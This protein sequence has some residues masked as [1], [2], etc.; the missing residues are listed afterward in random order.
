MDQVENYPNVELSKWGLVL[1]QCITVIFFIDAMCRIKRALKS[2]SSVL[3]MKSMCLQM[4]MFSLYIVSFTIYIVY[5]LL[6]NAYDSNTLTVDGPYLTNLDSESI[7]NFSF[8]VKQKTIASIVELVL[9]YSCQIIMAA[10]LL[11]LLTP[12]H[13]VKGE[14]TE[15][16]EGTEEEESELPPEMDLKNTF[17]TEISM[18]DLL[19]SSETQDVL[20]TPR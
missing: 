10:I 14:I 13:Q 18:P 2:Q 1:C 9:E 6:V 16:E 8:L 19:Q 4:S 17:D 15:E 7:Q 20:F 11:Q 3:N 12:N 5:A